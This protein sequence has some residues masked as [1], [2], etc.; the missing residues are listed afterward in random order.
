M[1]FGDIGLN[2][3]WSGFNIR[4]SDPKK[5]FIYKHEISTL[6][7]FE[8]P[9]NGLNLAIRKV[10]Y[11]QLSTYNPGYICNHQLTNEYHRAKIFYLYLDQKGLGPGG[12]PAPSC[13]TLTSR[14][15]NVNT[16]FAEKQSHVAKC[17]SKSS[18]VC[19]QR[20]YCC[21]LLW[22][23]HPSCKSY[24]DTRNYN[25]HHKDDWLF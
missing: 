10:F 24:N 20:K 18:R 5:S 23:I 11:I 7:P 25:N 15:S 17:K 2:T 19:R 16:F 22:R 12:V 1:A 14:R 6:T 4:R 21:F 9:S 3:L 8:K 13:T